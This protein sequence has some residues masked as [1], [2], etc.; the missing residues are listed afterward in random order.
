MHEALK[1]LVAAG[2]A[3]AFVGLGM[4]TG[5]IAKEGAP[6]HQADLRG[7]VVPSEVSR[8]LM[9]SATAGIEL[10][11]EACA[12]DQDGSPARDCGNVKV[13]IPQD[14]PS[15]KAFYETAMRA[16]NIKKGY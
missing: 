6:V 1:F 8:V 2:G 12:K 15:V 5:F 4:Y 14:E 16:W 11:I 7:P 10:E 3:A 9:R 13:T